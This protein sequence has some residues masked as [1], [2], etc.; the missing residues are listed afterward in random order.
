MSYVGW[1]SAEI[2][3]VLGVRAPGGRLVEAAPGAAFSV[4]DTDSAGLQSWDNGPSLGLSTAPVTRSR[5]PR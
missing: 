4:V 3:P 2:S 5:L 1:Q